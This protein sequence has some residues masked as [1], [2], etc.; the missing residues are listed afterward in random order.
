M[1]IGALIRTAYSNWRRRLWERK[2]QQALA[3]LFHQLDRHTREDIRFIHD[4]L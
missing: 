2:R 3:D 1:T 4:P